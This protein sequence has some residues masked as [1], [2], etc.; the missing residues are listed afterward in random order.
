M[1]I[2]MSKKST[3]DQIRWRFDADVERFSD[4]ES[5]QQAA[6]D[7]PIMMRLTSEAA[8][9]ASPRAKRMLDIGCGA[10]NFTLKVLQSKTDM[11]CD[12]VDLS[13][14]MIERALERVTEKTTGRVRAFQGDIRHVELD[15]GGYDIIVAAAVLHHLRGDEDWR[16]VFGKLYSLCAPGGSLWIVDLIRHDTPAIQVIMEKEYKDYLTGVG[17]SSYCDEV[18]AIIDQE[19]SPR[20]LSFQLELMRQVGFVQTEVLHKCGCYAAFGALKAPCRNGTLTNP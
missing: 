7:A 2:D 6:M 13:A 10:G 19:D 16:T 9:F 5:G 1:A 20:S 15:A 11:E 14:P 17:G 8:I 12:L 18:M 4:L 3:V